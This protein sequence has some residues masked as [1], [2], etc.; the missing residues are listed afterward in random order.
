MTEK[1]SIVYL[2]DEE[3]NLLS[4]K[5]VFRRYYNIYTALTPENAFKIIEDHSIDLVLSDQRMPKQTGVEFFESLNNKYPEIVRMI[6]TGYSDIQAIIDAIN[7]GK[8]YYY[9]KKPLNFE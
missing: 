9:I 5:A 1:Y 4:F 2:D 7:K 6:L 3:D 8:I